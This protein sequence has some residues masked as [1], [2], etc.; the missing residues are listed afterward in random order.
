LNTPSNTLTRTPST[1]ATPQPGQKMDFFPAA[2]RARKNIASLIQLSETRLDATFV[3]V[4]DSVFVQQEEAG[5][6]EL[7]QQEN[8][9][10][11][12]LIATLDTFLQFV[13]PGGLMDHNV[14]RG[15]NNIAAKYDSYT[16]AIEAGMTDQSLNDL[17]KTAIES[18]ARSLITELQFVESSLPLPFDS[19][20][21]GSTFII[22]AD[23]VDLFFEVQR[24]ID[25]MTKELEDLKSTIQQ[26]QKAKSDMEGFLQ[27]EKVLTEEIQKRKEEIGNLNRDLNTAQDLQKEGFVSLDT[28]LDSQSDS[29]GVVIRQVD[30]SIRTDL[31]NVV[32]TI[33]D[34]V[35][36]QKQESDSLFFRVGT[37]MTL[38][39][40]EIDSLKSV[41][42]YY[43]IAEKGLPE[44]NE[45]ILNILK[46]PTL[47]HKITLNNG[48]ILVGQIV[49]E[50]LDNI[51]LQTTVGKIVIE[52]NTIA[53]LDETF[54][55]GPKVEFEGDYELVEY[56]DREEFRGIVR[57]IGKKKADFVRVT[58]FLWD[59]NTN[60]IG[61]ASAFVNGITTKF[62]TGIIS[63]ASIDPGETA[64]Y[65]VIVEKEPGKKVAY[66]TNEIKWRDYK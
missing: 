60:A 48:T 56:E 5:L 44:I 14:T 57:N 45:D 19:L 50:N 63:N 23:S 12:D 40:E 55:P 17:E 20:K 33:T 31:S 65:H 2:E 36:S 49:E 26:Y 13:P 3:S 32:S 58:F 1:I 22:E 30:A 47:Q 52:K 21:V 24:D 38:F 16:K 4:E 29:I 42:R 18:N 64:T 7:K 62:T 39:Q 59:A 46:L 25:D 66:R 61:I 8:V 41:V 28:K 43:D 6:T 9:V 53:S 15:R 51:I 54:F 11:Q 37:N 27:R 35:T 34:S 10:F